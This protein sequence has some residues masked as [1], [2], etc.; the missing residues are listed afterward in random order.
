[1]LEIINEKYELKDL[2]KPMLSQNRIEE[3]SSNNNS[4]NNIYN[5][6]EKNYGRTITPLEVEKIQKWQ[7][8][9]SDEMIE[10]AIELSVMN[11]VKNFK[12][13]EGIINNWTSSQFKTLA[14]VKKIE[15]KEIKPIDTEL[16]EY[17]WLNEEE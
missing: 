4:S 2:A 8:Q 12:Y 13:I 9:F 15:K 10:Y 6:V 17:D 1:M 14:D 7:E 11:D 16:F 5:F 3:N